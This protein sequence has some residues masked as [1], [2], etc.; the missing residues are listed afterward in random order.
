MSII[1][2]APLL[3]DLCHTASIK[4]PTYTYTETKMG[5]VLV[6]KL[7]ITWAGQSKMR[8][9]GVSDNSMQNQQ[10]PRLTMAGW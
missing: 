1:I 10:R 6:W 2:S 9:L 7:Q 3:L 4:G 8:S 5:A